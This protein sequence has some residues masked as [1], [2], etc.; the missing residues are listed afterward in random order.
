MARSRRIREATA[1]AAAKLASGEQPVAAEFERIW[2]IADRHG[3]SIRTIDRW[4]EAG[5][6]PQPLRV[7][8][9]KFWPRGTLAS[10]N[11]PP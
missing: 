2:D 5:I 6:V 1:R 9:L 10:F 11:S 7:Q 4:I 8:R 3:V